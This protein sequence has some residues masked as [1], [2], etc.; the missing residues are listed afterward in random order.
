MATFLFGFA[1][2]GIGG[3]GVV[4]VALMAMALP[5]KASVGVVL[6]L[7]MFSDLFAVAYYRRHAQWKYLAGLLPAAMAGIVVGWLLFPRI[8]EAM[9]RPMIGVLVLGLSLVKVLLDRRPQLAESIRGRKTVAVA[10]GFV[11][12]VTTMLSNSAGPIMVIYLLAMGLPKFTFVGTGAW[13]FLIGNWFKVPFMVHL[14]RINIPSLTLNLKLAPAALVGI[15]AG[16]FVLK[17][18]GQKKFEAGVAGLAVVAGLVLIFKEP[19][20]DFLKS[21]SS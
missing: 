13:F 15:V 17:R 6:P 10:F 2:T 14:D 5:A 8:D 18:I 16:I 9:F 11:A 3:V 19:I 12:G 20:F 21:L 7:L 4:G 1:K